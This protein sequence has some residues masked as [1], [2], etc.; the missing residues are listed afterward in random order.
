MTVRAS[1][2]AI[3]APRGFNI[4]KCPSKVGDKKALGQCIHGLTLLEIIGKM[5]ILLLFL[6]IR[7]FFFYSD[8]K[9][10]ILLSF[11]FEREEGMNCSDAS[12]PTHL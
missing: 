12:P 5:N 6:K 3:G 8:E 7:Y 1:T 4:S 9:A 10:N 2:F 11:S